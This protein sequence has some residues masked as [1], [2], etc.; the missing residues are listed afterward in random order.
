MQKCCKPGYVESERGTGVPQSVPHG[1]LSTPSVAAGLKQPTPRQRRATSV[2]PV[3]LA[4][5]PIGCAAFP[6]ARE[7]GGL[8]PRLFTLTPAIGEPTAGAVVF[9]HIVPD[10]AIR[11][12][13]E[14]MELCVA[15][16][17][18]LPLPATGD[19]PHFCTI[20]YTFQSRRS[21]RRSS[22]FSSMSSLRSSLISCSTLHSLPSEPIPLAAYTISTTPEVI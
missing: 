8:L 21:S 5:Q 22:R 2:M 18:L 16:T 15:R 9:C 17:F 6:I 12:P 3:Y 4:L 10:V 13:L 7:A 20:I 1:H 11:F 19:R 14:S